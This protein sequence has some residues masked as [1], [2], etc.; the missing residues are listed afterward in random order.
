MSIGC[1]ILLFYAEYLWILSDKMSNLEMA[2]CALDNCDGRFSLFSD[3]LLIQL[4]IKRMGNRFI[5]YEK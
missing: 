4:L 2:A 5:N 3:M 1:F